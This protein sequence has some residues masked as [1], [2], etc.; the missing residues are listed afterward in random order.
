M[1]KIYPIPEKSG[2][3]TGRSAGFSRALL[4]HARVIAV[5]KGSPFKTISDLS[6]KVIGAST[7]AMDDLRLGD[8]VR[9]N[10][11]VGSLPAILAGIKRNYALRV[12]GDPVFFEPLATNNPAKS[13]P[14]LVAML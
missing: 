1:I 13:Q 7:A 6:G 14:I 3:I 10:G 2:K 11:M 4:L 8:G 12:L 9:I 5:H